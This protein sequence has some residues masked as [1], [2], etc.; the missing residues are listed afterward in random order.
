MKQTRRSK[1]LAKT[2]VFIA[3]FVLAGRTGCAV[4]QRRADRERR[5]A[6]VF[7]DIRLF[8]LLGRQLHGRQGV[9]HG[10]HQD[11]GLFVAQAPHQQRIRALQ[12]LT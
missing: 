9:Q 5:S 7:P 12:Q 3:A 11:L 8:R 4:G 2:L 10:P 6:R 1:L